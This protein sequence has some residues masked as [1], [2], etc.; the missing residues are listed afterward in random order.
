[1]NELIQYVLHE[2]F[3]EISVDLQ[4]YAKKVKFFNEQKK[5]IRERISRIRKTMQDYIT[6]QE[7]ILSTIGDDD[8]LANIDLQN[9]LQ[10][11][12]QTVQMMS[13]VSKVLHDTTMAVIRKSWISEKLS[14]LTTHFSQRLNAWLSS[15]VIYFN[16]H[17]L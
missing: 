15:S 11:Q 9:A 3:E 1:M 7:E 16:Y 6:S 8:Q 2:S 12:Q 13:N 4:Y 10:K 17:K 5:Q 14:Y